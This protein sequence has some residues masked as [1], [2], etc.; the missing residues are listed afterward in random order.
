MPS[1]NGQACATPVYLDASGQPTNRNGAVT[2]VPTAYRVSGVNTY[3]AA[4]TTY[5]TSRNTYVATCGSDMPLIGNGQ[6]LRLQPGT[7]FFSGTDV[8]MSNGGTI[9]CDGCTAGGPGVTLVFTGNNA[10]SVGTLRITGGNYTL[11]APGTNSG[12]PSVF[13]GIVVYRDNLGDTS[14][15]PNDSM[16]I[17]GNPNSTIFGAFYVPTGAFEM[18]GTSGMNQTTAGNC[19][20]VVAA[21]ITFGG[22]SDANI[23]ACESNGT[24][25]ARTRYVRFVL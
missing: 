8:R 13:D 12:N 17:T 11:I 20:A 3:T 7:Y 16:K 4:G 5:T 1:F 21:S 22:N 15:N 18:Y 6:T 24:R 10:A 25:V 2:I 23:D 14:N 19:V 9:T